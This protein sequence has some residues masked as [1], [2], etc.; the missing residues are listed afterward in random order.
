MNQN[1]HSDSKSEEN[2]QKPELKPAR[3]LAESFR[4]AFQGISYSLRTQRNMR[5]HFIVSVLVLIIAAI[6]RLQ[7]LEWVALLICMVLVI[8]SEL[9]NTAIEATVDL[10][11]PEKHKLAKI[12]KDSAAAAVLVFAVFSAVTGLLIFIHAALRLMHH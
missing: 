10:A 5:I 7:P 2:Y 9:T 12:A 3:R 4:Y 6:L 11:S 1:Q 8:G